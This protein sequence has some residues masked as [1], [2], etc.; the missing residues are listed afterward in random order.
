[1]KI[2][3]SECMSFITEM[4][5]KLIF[6]DVHI[7][8]NCSLNRAKGCIFMKHAVKGAIKADF[9][10]KNKSSN[11]VKYYYNIFY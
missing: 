4:Q 1:M 11:I 7:R 10:M 9:F 6:T 2:S 8:N 3:P 5:C